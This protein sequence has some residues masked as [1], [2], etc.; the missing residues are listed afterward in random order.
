MSLGAAPYTLAAAARRPEVRE[1]HTGQFAN[2]SLA[3]DSGVAL[4]ASKR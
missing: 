1:E 4:G 2:R 3:L